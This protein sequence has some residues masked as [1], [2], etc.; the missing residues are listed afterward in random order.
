MESE[1]PANSVSCSEPR[2]QGQPVGQN[3]GERL[4]WIDEVEFDVPVYGKGRRLVR[5]VRVPVLAAAPGPTRTAPN[6]TTKAV[7]ELLSAAGAKFRCWAT[8]RPARVTLPAVPATNCCSSNWPPERRIP[9][10]LCSRASSASTARSSSPAR[11]ASTPSAANTRRSAATTPCCT[12]PSPQP[13][14]GTRSSSRCSQRPAT[15][16]RSPITTRATSAGTTRCT[17]RHAS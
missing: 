11:T 14:S 4:T 15:P 9:Q 6:P 10:R 12:T 8:A 1:F 7:A 17:T 5:R 2:E 3:P 16:R 13:A